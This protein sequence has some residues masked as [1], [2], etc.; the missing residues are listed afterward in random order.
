MLFGN[1]FHSLNYICVTV[2]EK[3]KGCSEGKPCDV[4][5]VQTV[6]IDGKR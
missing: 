6:A 4:L 5:G 2:I 3:Q 1:T